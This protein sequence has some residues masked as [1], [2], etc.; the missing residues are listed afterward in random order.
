[1]PRSRLSRPEGDLDGYSS[2]SRNSQVRPKRFPGSSK[3][4]K[5]ERVLA[6]SEGNQGR[7]GMA[8]SH[9]WGFRAFLAGIGV[10]L[11]VLSAAVLFNGSPLLQTVVTRAGPVYATVEL[12]PLAYVLDALAI[13]AMILMVTGAALLSRPVASAPT[14]RQAETVLGSRD[15]TGLPRK[16]VVPSLRASRRPS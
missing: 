10:A 16:G 1:M 13:L 4:F 11:V 7:G 6:S 5:P 9:D 14:T 2:S 8:R 15:A 3:E 12:P